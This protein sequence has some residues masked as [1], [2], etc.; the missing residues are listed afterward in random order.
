MSKKQKIQI[1][2]MDDWFSGVY[3][4][5]FGTEKPS[6]HSYKRS[7]PHRHDYY[8]CVLLDKGTMEL[9]VD[10]EKVQLT[11]QTL[12]LSYPGQIHRIVS[13]RMDRGWFLAFDPAVL[14]ERLKNILDQRLS[15]VIIVPLSLEQSTGFCSFAAHLYKV[16][17]D[18]AQLFRHDITQSLMT[19]LVYQIASAY[20]S[21]EKSNLIR[22]SARNVEIT[23]TFKQK[24]RQNFKL[25]K[26]PSEYAAKMNV[27]VTH[28]NDT[29]RSVT[30]FPVT[31]Y[32]QQELMRE[33]R[34]LLYYA[35]LSVKEIA[36]ELGFEDEKYFNRLFNKVVGVSPGAFRKAGEI[37]F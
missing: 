7:E 3:I 5:P 31:Y 1:H 24:L 13:A 12:F 33:A 35:D 23:K 30:G 27:T 11:D 25:M 26:R 21:L 20:L 22:H 10:F 4:K 14:D 2:R 29:V 8:Y 37:L 6:G 15:E 28:L 16:Y 32:I 18:P 34:R 19:G 9:E 17:E 36:R